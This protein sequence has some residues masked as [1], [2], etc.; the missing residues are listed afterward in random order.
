[1][2]RPIIH[3]TKS[4]CIWKVSWDAVS[5]RSIHLMPWQW[6]KVPPGPRSQISEGGDRGIIMSSDFETN[7][8]KTDY[9]YR[10][11]QSDE[12][13]QAWSEFVSV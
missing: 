1:M 8:V 10:T 9:V 3:F 2:T 12:F 11:F 6:F 7:L 4:I 13:R 5:D